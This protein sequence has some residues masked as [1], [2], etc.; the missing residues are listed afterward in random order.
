M[1]TKIYITTIVVCWV[2]VVCGQPSV[3]WKRNYWWPFGCY[4]YNLLEFDDGGLKAQYSVPQQHPVS[5]MGFSESCTAISDTSGKLAFS[6]NGIFTGNKEHKRIDN[7]PLCEIL[8]P[9]VHTG[10]GC[11]PDIPGPGMRVPAG[12]GVASSSGSR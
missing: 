5:D 4:Y 8:D 3:D 1:K 9:P 10:I 7:E 2:L 12:S 6:S 11:E